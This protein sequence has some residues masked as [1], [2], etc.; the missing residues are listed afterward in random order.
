MPSGTAWM[1]LGAG[2]LVVGASMAARP[3]RGPVEAIKIAGSA[4][5]TY[6]KRDTVVVPD[7]QGHSLSVGQTVGKNRNTGQ[8]D[9]FADGDVLNAETSDLV[10]GNGPH[11]GYFTLGKGV[12]TTVAKW[13]GEVKTKMS[14]ANQPVTTF[15]GKWEYVH[16]AGGY[17]K[18]KGS[19]K[20][21]GQFLAPDRYLVTWEGNYSK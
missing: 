1:L 10:Q 7:S 21:K 2:T 12:D 18:I 17:A 9:Y 20:Y 3:G 16:G 8:V 13:Q 15:E 14:P 11:Q 19:G 5:L 6:T 4:E